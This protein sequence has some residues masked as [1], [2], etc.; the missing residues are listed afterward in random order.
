MIIC[1][2]YQVLAITP[3]VI[4]VLTFAFRA[5]FYWSIP[6]ADGEPKGGGD[7]I[8]ILLFLLLIGSCILSILFSALLAVIPK[9]RNNTYS[10]KL[11]I[12]GV[13]IPLV[14]WVIHPFI[15]RLV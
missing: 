4:L 12:I 8:E 10:L 3:L 9:I 15:P 5:T 1:R 13:L 6:V 11:L 14:F 2:I 7:V